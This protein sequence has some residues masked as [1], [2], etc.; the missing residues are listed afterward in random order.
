VENLPCRQAP[1][2]PYSSAAPLVKTTRE[3]INQLDAAVCRMALIPFGDS[4]KPSE[5][6]I[7]IKSDPQLDAISHAALAASS[8]RKNQSD[9]SLVA[10]GRKVDNRSHSL[11]RGDFD[12][13]MFRHFHSRRRNNAA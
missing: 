6:F 1:K 11:V 12:P 8:V 9:T 10:H 3:P 5:N 7:E 13:H 2:L 4:L